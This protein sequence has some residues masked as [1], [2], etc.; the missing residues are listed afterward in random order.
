M[1]SFS[2]FVAPSLAPFCARATTARAVCVPGRYHQIK[3]QTSSD[4]ASSGTV[5]PTPAKESNTPNPTPKQ[6]IQE[7]TNDD[8]TNAI[9]AGIRGIPSRPV[10]YSFLAAGVTTSF[11]LLIISSSIVSYIDRI[12]VLRD[13]LRLVRWQYCSYLINDCHCS[14]HPNSN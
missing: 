10:F 3:A 12:P 5:A 6:F 8:V 4:H 2:A 9:T 7:D 1:L 14:I 13:I 11:V